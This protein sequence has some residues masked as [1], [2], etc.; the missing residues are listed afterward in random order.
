MIMLAIWHP[1]V[2]NY[3]NTFELKFFDI[4]F[5]SLSA[6][7]HNNFILE[8]DWY[9]IDIQEHEIEIKPQW[10]ITLLFQNG[11]ELIFINL[12]HHPKIILK[13]ETIKPGTY[14]L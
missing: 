4:W 14:F 1:L 12:S 11:K 9:T 13:I 10:V 5:C 6:E 3:Q 8:N 7:V 2:C